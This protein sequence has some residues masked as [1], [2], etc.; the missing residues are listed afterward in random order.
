MPRRNGPVHVATTKRIYKGKVYVT[1]LLRRSY[2]EGGKVKH[3]TLGNLSHLPAD[4]IETVRSRLAGGEPLVRGGFDILRSL[5]HGHVAALLGTLRKI[6]LE[7]L[8][9]ARPCRER[10]LV[11]AMIVAR[12]MEPSSKLATARALCERTASCS[13]VW[14]LGL[15]EPDA[16]ADE[17]DLYAAMDW[18]L[19]RQTRIETK[20]AKKH[21]EDGTLLLYDVSG[22]YYTG[23]HCSLAEFGYPRDRK[24]GFPQIVYGLL[25]NAAGC[26]VAIHVFPG[27]TGDPSTLPTQIDKV[28]KRFGIQRVVMVGDRGM[29]TS[30]RITES[31]RG[32]PGVDWITALRADSIKKLAS[33][34]IIQ[35]SL[36][37]ERDLAE[38]T[39]PDY[40]DERLVVCRN[41][42]LADERARKREDLLQ[43]TEKKLEEV[44]AATRRE[45]RALRGKDRIAL[46]VGKVINH[47][48]VGKHFV[49][50]FGED[51]FSYHRDE[52]KIAEE[53]ALDGLYVIRT[54]VSDDSLNSDATVRAYK[55]LAK[56]ERAFRCM[57]TID[58]H[59]R[60]IFHWLADRVRAHVFLCMLSY[61]LEWHLR[62]RLA[63][64]LFDDHD[65]EA[66]EALRLS[67]V[68]PAERSPAAKQKDRTKQTADGLPVHSLRTLL[69]DLGTLTKNRIRLRGTRGEFHQLTEAT[70]LQRRAFELLGVT[71]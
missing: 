43:A 68:A 61:Y 34:G 48:K 66:A 58:L 56:V 40:P 27:N 60:P 42:L 30:R 65:R 14:E 22:S 23:T 5:P 29:I 2:R 19:A 31:M 44:A 20:L 51:S 10:T 32:V 33:Q 24:K 38:V 54:S 26:P 45:K 4:L 63:P 37:D 8:L 17:R 1:H 41:P 3:E 52:A 6:G 28:R 21:L 59:V 62:K 18:L 39:S 13:L 53:A 55:D 70:E 12:L 71:P 11:V 7:D 67:V 46:R 69:A 64:L 9:G 25:C 16:A 49:L 15:N 57:K 36:F 47:Y 35:A 50:E